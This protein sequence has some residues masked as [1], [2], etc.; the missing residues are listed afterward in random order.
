[1]TH[2]TFSSLGL[3]QAWLENLD[4]LGYTTM[5]PIQAEALPLM[6]EG[7]DVIGEASTGTGKT[8]AFALTLLA[9]IEP[10]SDLPGALVLCPTRE[11]AA[12]VAAE[13]RRL[14]RPLPHTN[15]ETITGG[16]PIN[17][18][19]V[20]LEHGVDVIVATPGR[21]LDHLRRETVDLSKVETLV[22]DE[23]DRMLDMG[24]VDDVAEIAEAT[25][26]KRQ[27]LLMS[28]TASQ[29]VRVLGRRFQTDAAFISVLEDE[30]DPDI[31]QHLFKIGDTERIQALRFVLASHKPDSAVI[32]CNQRDTTD[33]V[34]DVL[35]QAG[36][37]AS[38]LHGGYEQ[39]DRDDILERFANGS[40]RLLVATNVAARGI[41]IDEIDA[42]INYELPRDPNEYIHRIGRTG[43]AGEKG[44]AISLCGAYAE[45]K[46]D[47][48][49][50][51]DDVLQG[52]PRRH[53]D[54]I[55]GAQETPRPPKN[56]TIV[57]LG[58]RKQ[59]LRPGD[60][61]G[62]LTGEL[63]ID[64]DAIGLITV[65][66]RTTHVAIE[67]SVAERAHAEINAGKIKGRRFQARLL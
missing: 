63:G 23:C 30:P 51:V 41:D 9:K 31:T 13:I 61:V 33:H 52:V 2:H 21:L 67:R 50:G 36:Y 34:A 42:V 54:E 60:I 26:Q 58:G 59:K 16:S 37:S 47:K 45:A 7:R 24:F 12:Q 27:T 48:I 39:R 3:S 14:A 55:S 10:A 4:Q 65:A 62:A 20:S 5:T 29:E 1:M 15:V 28:A 46:L 35:Q 57:I 19:I 44:C 11:L 17:R 22:F 25:P 53:I 40:L 56:K 49:N 6:L 64:G 66:D 43:R 32:F 18:Q 38:S 8:A